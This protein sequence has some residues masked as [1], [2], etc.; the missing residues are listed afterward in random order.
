MY[1]AMYTLF[2]FILPLL[3]PYQSHHYIRLILLPLSMTSFPSRLFCLTPNSILV[4]DVISFYA[5]SILLLASQWSYALSSLI[6]DSFLLSCTLDI[7]IS[8]C[9]HWLISS[10]P[11]KGCQ[12][13]LCYNNRQRSPLGIITLSIMPTQLLSAIG[14]EL[15]QKIQTTPLQRCDTTPIFSTLATML[16]FPMLIM[17]T[18]MF[19][20]SIPT[21]VLTMLTHT[22]LTPI[23]MFPFPIL[24]I[25][26]PTPTPTPMFP[27]FPFP[28]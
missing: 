1:L 27:M 16:P 6:S 19:P 13:L 2:L 12:S 17:P 4:H 8:F 24:A 25:P 10:S 26:T 28:H 22:F 9:L 7:Y 23:L 15:L 21:P 14:R 20:I 11:D 5:L 3:A 18:T